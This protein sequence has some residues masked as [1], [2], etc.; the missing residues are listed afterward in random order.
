MRA[1]LVLLSS[2]EMFA[3]PVEAFSVKIGCETA[4]ESHESLDLL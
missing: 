3:Y 2:I 4:K 1:V